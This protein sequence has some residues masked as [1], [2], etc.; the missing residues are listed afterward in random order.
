[1]ARLTEISERNR[2][3]RNV[4]R[5]DDA[6]RAHP[7]RDLP[8]RPKPFSDEP[9]V[10]IR[11][12]RTLE[13]VIPG[14]ELTNGEG[15]TYLREWRFPLSHTH[16]NW[17]LGRF[18]ELHE[19]LVNAGSD[20][21]GLGG[22]FDLSQV[23]FFD[24]ET[25]GLAGGTGTYIILAGLGLFQNSEFIIRQLILRDYDEEPAL[26]E[27]VSNTVHTRSGLISFNGRAFDVPLLST[28]LTLFG[29]KLPRALEDN[30][31]DLLH[32]ARRVYS[33]RLDS[34][35]LSSI[36]PHILG[37]HREFDVPGAEIPARYFAYLQE[38][39]ATYLEGIC[40][41]NRDDL[42]S[43][44]T[45]ATSLMVLAQYPERGHDMP[46]DLIGLGRAY[47][48][49]GDLERAVASYQEGL[50]K[51]TGGAAGQDRFFRD[52][53]RGSLSMEE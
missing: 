2:H 30:H 15:I 26:L 44:V 47:E 12:T 18:L 8:A 7:G 22:R 9:V 24:T 42:L 11:H 49:E 1:M 3:T 23:A 19:T 53:G 20:P 31:W 39:D 51:L 14:V 13:E 32:T 29:S 37:V 28:R 5:T 33:L 43:L 21:F 48:L 40:E 16:G 52:P 34:C 4:L 38:Q 35:A 25:T 10:R 27:A 46:H 6:P 50:H 45:L 36:E 41:H 17:A